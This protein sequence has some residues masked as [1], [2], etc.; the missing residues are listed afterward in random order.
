[1]EFQEDVGV[2]RKERE[3]EAKVT[4]APWNRKKVQEKKL[5]NSKLQR[6]YPDH[7]HWYKKQLIS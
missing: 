5:L 1:M 4:Q 6:T 7:H 2:E 3:R